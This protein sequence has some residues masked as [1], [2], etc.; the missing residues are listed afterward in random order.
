MTDLSEFIQRTYTPPTI[1]LDAHDFMQLH[2]LWCSSRLERRRW[3]LRTAP[4]IRNRNI[5]LSNGGRTH[6]LK[7]LPIPHP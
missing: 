4:D 6:S 7:W 2:N 1:R 5:M 3:V